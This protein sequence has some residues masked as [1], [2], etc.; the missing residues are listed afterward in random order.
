MS[1]QVRGKGG[2]K[3]KKR[4]R[5]VRA[6][7]L[8]QMTAPSPFLIHFH[9][10]GTNPRLVKTSKPIEDR[11]FRKKDFGALVI[12]LD[13]VYHTIYKSVKRYFTDPN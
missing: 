2:G 7:T 9:N 11:L 12:N 3:G 4:K 1:N 6:K 8:F 10:P 5:E 13:M